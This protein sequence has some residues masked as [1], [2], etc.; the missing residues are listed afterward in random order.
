MEVL[1]THFQLNPTFRLQIPDGESEGSV[2][3]LCNV[4]DGVA[5]LFSQYVPTLKE[6]LLTVRFYPSD[7]TPMCLRSQ[8]M[9]LLNCE[10][11]VWN[12]AA[13]QFAHELCHF[14]IPVDVHPKL[15][16]IEESICQAASIFFLFQLADTF[17]RGGH[18]YAKYFSCYAEKDARKAT[19]FNWTDRV[20]LSALRS[21]PYLREK[22]SYIANHL[23]PIIWEEPKLWAAVPL[24]GFVREVSSIQA[25]LD[26]WLRLVPLDLRPGL[27]RIKA[28]LAS[29]PPGYTPPNIP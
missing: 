23:L 16:W 14:T 28:V 20:E 19:P 18:P 2:A 17:G 26:E 4:L 8:H 3:N 13:Y 10:I 25:A 6:K 27:L 29:P 7:D 1:Y 9:I 24:L 5:Y 15:R 22:N 21:D 11:D 12:Q